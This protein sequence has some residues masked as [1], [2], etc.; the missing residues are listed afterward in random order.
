MAEM[1]PW[2]V[3]EI[4]CLGLALYMGF[5][6]DSFWSVIPFVGF[7]ICDFVIETIEEVPWLR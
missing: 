5:F 4:I 2:K 6:L 1:W 7:L 3:G